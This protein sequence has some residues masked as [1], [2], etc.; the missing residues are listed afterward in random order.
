[1]KYRFVV[2]KDNYEHLSAGRVIRSYPGMTSFPVRLA[3]EVFQACVAYAGKQ[4]LRLYDPCCGS[5]YLLTVLGLLY[6]DQLEALYGSDI[7][8][9]AVEAA[10]KNLKLLSPEGLRAREQELTALFN[11][12][13]K[14]SHLAALDSLHQLAA[15]LPER[16]IPAHSWVADAMMPVLAPRSVDVMMTD[17]PYG[18]LVNWAGSAGEQPVYTLLENQ[19]R[20]LAPAAVAAI[21]SDKSIRVQ[22]PAYQ[23]LQHTNHG[24]RR[25]T[26]L[27][28][29]MPANQIEG[30]SSTQ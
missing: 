5:G 18:Q 27:R 10:H 23:R 11:E 25:I 1:M 30:I 6:P 12:Y 26:I 21:I 4:H 2:A 28:L 8:P 22:H 24:K 15:Q 17:L 14:E 20:V 9:A 7:N 3:S 29:I 19:R 16:P 13:G